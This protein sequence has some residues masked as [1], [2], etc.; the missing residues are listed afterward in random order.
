[1]PSQVGFNIL[2]HYKHIFPFRIIVSICDFSFFTM[3]EICERKVAN[4]QRNVKDK[5]NYSTNFNAM[6][7][8]MAEPGIPRR[9]GGATPIRPNFPK[10]L[11]ENKET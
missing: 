2:L 5:F 9:G 1:M 3:D 6:F 8:D 7:L 11:N 10:K 4:G